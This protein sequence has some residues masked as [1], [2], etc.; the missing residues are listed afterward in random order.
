ME[1]ALAKL[2]PGKVTRTT[3]KEAI[4]RK[5][6]GLLK[7]APALSHV[8]NKTYG[9]KVSPVCAFDFTEASLS[10]NRKNHHVI[11]L[12]ILHEQSIW[13]FIIHYR[14]FHLNGDGNKKYLSLFLVP[15]TSNF[16]TPK[17]K[18]LIR[19]LLHV[20]EGPLNFSFIALEEI[21]P[22][23]EGSAPQWRQSSLLYSACD[24][25]PIPKNFFKAVLDFENHDN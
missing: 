16:K 5:V 22:T 10:D 8:L 20:F 1:F 24:K 3:D 9:N 2:N 21:P 18:T 15:A 13:G 17:F 6:E 19:R 14:T 23:V 7:E 25:S 11:V 4:R 12:K